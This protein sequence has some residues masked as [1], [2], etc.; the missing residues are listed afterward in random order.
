MAPLRDGPLTTGEVNAFAAATP[1]VARTDIASKI[2]LTTRRLEMPRV[3]QLNGY[4]V[5]YTEE[6]AEAARGYLRQDGEAAL[7]AL[8]RAEAKESDTV[9]RW[10]ISFLRSQV[11]IMMGRAAEVDDLLKDTAQREISF[12]GHDLNTRALRGEARLWLGDVDGAVAD[13]ARVWL[14]LRDW[15]LPTFYLFP[16]TR[17]GLRNR[18]ILTTAQVRAL[19]G[20]A[21][22]YFLKGD[23]PAALAWAAEGEN[24]LDD[25][26]FVLHNPIFG[27]FSPYHT[28]AYYL[29][30]LNTSFLAAAMLVV[31]RDTAAAEKLFHSVVA[32]YDAVGYAA[33]RVS[34][35]ALKAQALTKIGSYA[36]AIETATHAAALAV[37]AGLGD[38]LWRV[39]L[40]QGEILLNL[41][42]KHEAEVALRRAQAGVEAVS[43]ALS[44]D[45]AKLRFGAG[46]EAITY[47]LARL[48]A[49]K[50]D[51]P[52]LFRDLE[53]GRARAF[54]DMLAGR[55][56]AS[57]REVALVNSL[58]DLDRHILRIRLLNAAPGDASPENLK[59]E[60][61]WL[62]ERFQKVAAL[63]ARD[64]ELSDAFAVAA[65]EMEEVQSRLGAGEVLAYTL[66]ARE[67]E[68]IRFLVLTTAS[69]RLVN[70]DTTPRQLQRTLNSLAVETRARVKSNALPSTLVKGDQHVQLQAAARL[71]N[72]LRIAEWDV[73]AG[74]FVVPSGEIHFV[75]WGALDITYPVAVIPTAG[76]VTRTARSLAR[77]RA[78]V[79][80]GDPQFGDILPQLPGARAEAQA[81]AAL[82]QTLP[83]T[84]T[85]ATV[86]AL[87]R[88]VG[89][90]VDV[91]HLATHSTFD[92]VNPLQSVLYLSDGVKAAELSAADLFAEPLPSKLVVLS[93]CETGLG[94]AVAGDDFLGLARSFYIGG[95]RAVLNSLW[96][97]E[98]TGTQ[99]FMLAFHEHAVTGRYGDAW[100]RARDE[101]K[102]K[103]FPPSIYGAFVLGGALRD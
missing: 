7:E 24:R 93:A 80:V 15:R 6:L 11:L 56:L 25:M 74:L 71:Q 38:M 79:V 35:L 81:I 12:A 49:E 32:F 2:P 30:A 53:R 23:Y 46:K 94:R 92:A 26:F 17:S 86:K 62:E 14:T 98:D 50:K 67:H 96:E 57:G 90:G 66:P 45:N 29:R 100:L 42:Q 54:V 65:T 76:W 64:P 31:N 41:G 40:L 27:L 55:A 89:S 70:S 8:D 82:Y 60:S 33:G 43:G 37:R 9:M 44:A 77:T 75:P 101:L 83:L 39:E 21:G 22:I 87:R 97:V 103:G 28:D 13:F 88:E 47:H 5:R 102:R 99:A 3:G 51:Y 61:R 63:R 18:Y 68:R 69:A 4:L 84:G 48:D 1:P 91:L 16:P 20:L 59:L 10:Q 34:A 58:R 73:S 78:A 72:D 19:A 52:V 36:S 85:D 95:T